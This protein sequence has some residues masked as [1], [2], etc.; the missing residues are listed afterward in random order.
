M[1]MVKVLLEDLRRG[2]LLGRLTVAVSL[3]YES[4]NPN[5]MQ[6]LWG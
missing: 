1:A 4:V 6:Q 2:G 3:C 5:I